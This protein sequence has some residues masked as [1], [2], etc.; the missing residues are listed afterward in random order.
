MPQD[1]S[2]QEYLASTKWGGAAGTWQSAGTWVLPT[3]IAQLGVTSSDGGQTLS[4]SY[5][6]LNQ[7]PLQVQLTLVTNPSTDPNSY[8]SQTQPSGGT[9]WQP[10]PTWQFGG[11]SVVSLILSSNNPPEGYTVAGSITHAGQGPLDLK[12]VPAP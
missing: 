1:L 8:T 4:G 2:I 3:S 6:T 10:G 9:G 7:S 12:A 11:G 5:S